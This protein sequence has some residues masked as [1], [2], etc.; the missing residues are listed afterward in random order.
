MM[1]KYYKLFFN[2]ILI[3]LI[4]FT[5]T[6]CT[7]QS[8]PPIVIE[9]IYLDVP[10]VKQEKPTWCL[11]ASTKSVM[12]YWGMEITQEELVDY[13]IDE[14]G[15][16]SAGTLKENA[17]KLGIEV[18]NE[19]KS[20]EEIKNEIK[21]G[22]PVIVVLDYNL[23]QKSNHFYVIDGFN[24]EKMRLMCPVRGFI[25]WSYD[26]LKQLNDNLWIDEVGET[27]NLYNT[28]LVWPKD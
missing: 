26:Y 8:L 28:T 5:L 13:V 9:E 4:S 10:V 22:N 1:K 25:Y 27:S 12:N 3:V 18:Y 19:L 14:V 17:D 23:E 2:L 20:L 6:S 21:K 11:P 16:G 24:E 7:G 15:W